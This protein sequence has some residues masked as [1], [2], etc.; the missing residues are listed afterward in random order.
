VAR[1]IMRSTRT[2]GAL[3]CL[4]VTCPAIATASTFVVNSTLDA[5]DFNLG[6]G[7]CA[8]SGGVC[9][10]RA[11]IQEANIFAGP[12]VITL[13]AG[14]RRGANGVSSLRCKRLTGAASECRPTT[15]R[16]ESHFA[17]R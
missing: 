3:F 9:T 7:V 2:V 17:S 1:G 4:A 12:H 14:L 16:G 15:R 5:V 13:P 8:T 10:L 6:D 11:A